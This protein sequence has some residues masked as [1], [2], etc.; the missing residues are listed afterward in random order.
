[1]LP[2]GGLRKWLWASIHRAKLNSW[3]KLAI[4]IA[5]SCSRRVP[6]DGATQEIVAG[7][8]QQSARG[9]TARIQLF[10]D[11][12]RPLKPPADRT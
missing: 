7:Q 6:A 1:L 8:D 5:S 4:D 3:R 2:T 12:L 10:G 11:V 9:A